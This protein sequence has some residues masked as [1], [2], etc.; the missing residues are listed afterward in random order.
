MSGV[1]TSQYKEARM[2]CTD[3]QHPYMDFLNFSLKIYCKWVKWS[4][5]FG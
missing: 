5:V 1:I 2:W 4:S 3:Y